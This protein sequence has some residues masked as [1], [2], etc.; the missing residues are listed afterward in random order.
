MGHLYLVGLGQE[1]QC[2]HPEG[3]SFG[4]D[5]CEFEGAGRGQDKDRAIEG[6]RK[7]RSFREWRIIYNIEDRLYSH[8]EI[9]STVSSFKTLGKTYVCDLSCQ[10]A[11]C[12]NSAACY[13]T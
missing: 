5:C 11:H 4:V 3:M 6:R 8:F 1:R 9:V 12:Q 10:A 13:P 7:L 2:G